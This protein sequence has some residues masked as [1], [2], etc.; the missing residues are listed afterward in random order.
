MKKLLLLAVAMSS[1]LPSFAE[2][3]GN[4]GDTCENRIKVIRNDIES[5]ILRGGAESL[6]LPSGLS[7]QEY[8]S[9]MLSE[10][11]AGH[12]VICT[13]DKLYVGRAEKT[14]KNYEGNDILLNET[15]L[16]IIL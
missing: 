7:Y 12:P 16:Q 11:K 4:G 2:D 14:C 13:D 8:E 15:K 1:I 10:L 6:K 5:W 3:K 9:A